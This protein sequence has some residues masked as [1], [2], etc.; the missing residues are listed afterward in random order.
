MQ[1]NVDVGVLERVQARLIEI[2]ADQA[3]VR[4][5]KILH[6]LGFDSKVKRKMGYAQ[7]GAKTGQMIS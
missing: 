7:R 1:E 3:V 5:A 2:E 6:G 4:A